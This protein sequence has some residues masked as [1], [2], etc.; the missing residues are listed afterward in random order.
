MRFK[1]QL[2]VCAEGGGHVVVR[3]EFPPAWLR[4]RGTVLHQRWSTAFHR[5]WGAAAPAGSRGLRTI[6]DASK[7]TFD[8]LR[9][10]SWQAFARRHGKLL[11]G[12]GA[13]IFLTIVLISAG[14]IVWKVPQ[15]QA[16]TWEGRME[17]KD[18]AKLEN[19]ARTALIQAIGGAVL[20]LGFLATAIG[21][22]LTWRN[23]QITQNTAL[24][25]LQLT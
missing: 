10:M 21:L 5:V 9:A 16:A 22:V 15:W 1:V 18:L 23:L 14:L 24:K 19:D 25:N 3:G 6:K 7:N 12:I 17:A 4:E 8:R 2:V 20:L 11:L 13:V